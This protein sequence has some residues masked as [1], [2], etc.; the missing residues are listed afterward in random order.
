MNLNRKKVKKGKYRPS[1]K[2]NLMSFDCAE[3]LYIA[4]FQ[5]IHNKNIEFTLKK[6][7]KGKFR[8]STK[9]N[10]MSFDGAENRYV[11]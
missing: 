3:N 4:A 2:R 7:K 8:P 11:G 9:K 1:T 6:F 10:P 5:V